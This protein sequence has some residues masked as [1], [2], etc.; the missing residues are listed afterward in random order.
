MAGSIFEIGASGTEAASKSLGAFR[1]R[2]SSVASVTTIMAKAGGIM[3]ALS[4]GPGQGAIDEVMGTL[5]MQIEDTRYQLAALNKEMESLSIPPKEDVTKL[6]DDL[7]KKSAY[8]NC[9]FDSQ[10][11]AFDRTMDALEA[12][13]HHFTLWNYTADNT[14]ERGDHWNDE[15]LS[16]FSRDQQQDPEDINSGGRALEAVIRPYPLA[17]AGEPLEIRFEIKSKI[18]EF[19]FRHDPFVKEPTEVFVPLYQYP[20]GCQVEVSDGEYEL[21]LAEQTLTYWHSAEVKEHSIRLKPDQTQ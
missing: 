1:K 3:A 12:N 6:C 18:F 16:I 21:N 2:L 14:N 9:N 5:N 11:N 15:D 4:G 20:N 8:K 10:I 19:R 7:N 17:T 13:M